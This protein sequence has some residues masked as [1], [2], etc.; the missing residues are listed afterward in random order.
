M[1]LQDDQQVLLTVLKALGPC[2]VKVI[3]DYTGWQSEK[4]R[5]LL[6]ALLLEKKIDRRWHLGV[7]F[8]T[9]Y[10]RYWAIGPGDSN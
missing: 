1:S 4:I 10:Y 7:T 5:V 6:R 2:P 8:G 9:S 3:R